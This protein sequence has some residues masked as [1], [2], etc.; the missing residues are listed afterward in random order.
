MALLAP[1]MPACTRQEP[2]DDPPV[3]QELV[4]KITYAMS[5]SFDSICGGGGMELWLIYEKGDYDEL[6]FVMT[7]P[8]SAG[9]P[10]N[11]NVAWPTERTEESVDVL[12][13]YIVL[14][15]Y[16]LEPYSLTY[17]ITLDD[18]VYDWENVDDLMRNG[19]D[20]TVRHIVF[21]Y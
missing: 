18:V 13:R 12:N 19:V 16:D 15:G 3:D 8:E 9:Y 7:E 20:R 1:A 14:H 17:P 11:V 5:F 2:P 21:G 10:A 4:T 6:V